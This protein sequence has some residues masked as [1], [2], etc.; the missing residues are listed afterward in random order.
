MVSCVRPIR[1]NTIVIP[2]L[3]VGSHSH[4]C[5]STQ[6]EANVLVAGF[7]CTW[8]SGFIFHLDL[9]EESIHLTGT[10]QLATCPTWEFNEETTHSKEP[11]YDAVLSIIHVDGSVEEQPR[12]GG[13]RLH[14]NQSLQMHLTTQSP[15]HQCM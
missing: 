13:S 2:G 7:S 12:E 6:W 9:T 11:A 14:T 5:T 3:A 8:E 15:S 4:N 10:L 1:V